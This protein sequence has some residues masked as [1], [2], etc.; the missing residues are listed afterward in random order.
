[1]IRHVGHLVC[2][3]NDRKKCLSF[4]IAGNGSS[5]RLIWTANASELNPLKPHYSFKSVRD[6]CV[7]YKNSSA[8]ISRR[9]RN[10]REV[11][12]WWM[13]EDTEGAASE[14]YQGGDWTNDT[15]SK[16]P[17]SVEWRKRASPSKSVR[18]L[19]LQGRKRKQKVNSPARI[20]GPSSRRWVL[21]LR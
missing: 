9:I 19:I 16:F 7:R 18:Q 3:S 13:G 10:W 8:T 6:K 21:Y 20:P 14:S 5:D 12:R 15:V 4:F 2:S 11:G 1:M 17:R